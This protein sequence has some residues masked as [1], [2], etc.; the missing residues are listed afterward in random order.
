MT[1]LHEGMNVLAKQ[2][3]DIV[4]KGDVDS[5]RSLLKEENRQL[6]EIKKT[7]GL[8]VQE[9][10]AFLEQRGVIADN[11]T[12]L[13]VIDVVEDKT[14]LMYEKERLETQIDELRKQ[15]LL[16]QEMLTQSLQWVQISLDLLQPDIDSYNYHR[17]DNE[18][19]MNQPIRTIFDSN[20]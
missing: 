9:T 14:P 10:K 17:S 6:Q 15:N 11:P 16:N 2:K 3:T 8:L 12:L 1:L 20:A 5:L 7:E 13:E 18:R 4:K 19:D